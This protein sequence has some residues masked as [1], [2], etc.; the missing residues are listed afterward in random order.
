M[1]FFSFILF[2]NKKYIVLLFYNYNYNLFQHIAHDFR[3]LF[4][5]PTRNREF[6]GI[7]VMLR[8]R[9]FHIPNHILLLLFLIT[10]Y[11]S[12]SDLHNLISCRKV[13]TISVYLSKYE[14]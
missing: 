12:V 7:L 1:P 2:I 14:E 5:P 6:L 4:P 11:T 3:E 10:Y 9:K 13:F 8:S